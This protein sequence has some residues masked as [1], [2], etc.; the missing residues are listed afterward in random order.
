MINCPF[1]IFSGNVEEVGTCVS[2]ARAVSDE[3]RP[4]PRN[5]RPATTPAAAPKKTKNTVLRKMEQS[6]YSL[7]AALSFVV[8]EHWNV[9]PA[10]YFLISVNFK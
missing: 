1:I 8:A 6:C 5:T 4:S 7:H 2:F 10:M 9:L 3:S